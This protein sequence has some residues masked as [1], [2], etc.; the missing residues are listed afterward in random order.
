MEE[1]YNKTINYLKHQKQFLIDNINEH[2]NSISYIREATQELVD[3][4][5]KLKYYDDL[6][7]ELYNKKNEQTMAFQKEA[8]VNKKE[9]ITKK[10]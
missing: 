6:I 10:K 4:D 8:K 3:I 7:K 1:E 9:T 2:K 5:K